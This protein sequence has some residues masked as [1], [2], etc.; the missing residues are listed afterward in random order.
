MITIS[1]EEE[2][3]NEILKE[4]SRVK[5]L[6][7][8]SHYAVNIESLDMLVKRIEFAFVKEAGRLM[9]ELS[10]NPLE[11]KEAGNEVFVKMSDMIQLFENLAQMA[12]DA[13]ADPDKMMSVVMNDKELEILCN[14]TQELTKRKQ[15]EVPHL[16]VENF[17][18]RLLAELIKS[19]VC[20]CK[21]VRVGDY[22]TK[23]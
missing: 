3:A 12:I 14:L 20:A 9:D 18:P 5:M 11:K 4:I 22:E 16:C 19:Y 10:Y 8:D 7:E 6:I 17:S 13:G 2:L 23:D 21:E 15:I 1:L